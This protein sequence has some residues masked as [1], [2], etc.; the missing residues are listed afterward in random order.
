M[1][2]GFKAEDVSK[3]EMFRRAAHPDP[4]FPPGSTGY[5]RVIAVVTDDPGFAAAVDRP[6]FELGRPDLGAR[7]ADLVEASV[8][9]V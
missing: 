5:D 8:M 2:E 9:D 6:G 1:V 7:L 4:V 3:I